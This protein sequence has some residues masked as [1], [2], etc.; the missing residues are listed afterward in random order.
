MDNEYESIRHARNA[1][2]SLRHAI[3]HTYLLANHMRSQT[4]SLN[5]NDRIKYET[6]TYT[7]GFMARKLCAIF[8]G[9]TD[10][11]PEIQDL[12]FSFKYIEDF[13]NEIK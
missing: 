6:W 7:L 4:I 1:A 12:N 2:L 3:R 10:Y 5:Q 13:K 11:E 9:Q 8:L